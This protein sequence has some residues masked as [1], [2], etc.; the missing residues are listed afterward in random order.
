[1]RLIA[2]LLATAFALPANGEAQLLPF[3]AFAARD[4]RPGPGKSWRVDNERGAKLAADLTAAAK[5]T[6]V[7]I[8][9]DHNTL[10]VTRHGQRAP[11]AGW[12]QSA[13]WRD[14][15]GLFASVEWTDTAKGLIASGE[16]R[17]ISPVIAFD[18]ETG[19]VERVALAALVNHP[20]LQGMQAAVAALSTEFLSSLNPPSSEPPTMNELLL[21]LL[22][23]L[24]LKQDATQA[25]ALAALGALQ[26]P[27][28]STALA[29]ALG[30]AADADE[31]AQLAAL[32]AIKSPAGDDGATAALLAMQTQLAALQNKLVAGERE[33][34]V[35][36]ALSTG[37]LIPALVPWANTLSV[38]ALSAYIESAPVVAPAKGQSQG[39]AQHGA[40]PGDGVTLSPTQAMLASQLGIDPK[41]YAKQL[42][43][44]PV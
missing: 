9:Y 44:A 43:A 25:Q 38:E 36:A 6:P 16:Y 30:V 32:T 8:D 2:A 40:K 26:K 5:A 28:L 42:A 11:A 27:K 41:E 21:A 22:N 4:G 37:R 20:A 31:A 17:Y 29:T 23:A 19:A 12:I 7:V 13:E 35:Q 1:M 14:G 24:G 33:G 39:D 3:G 15:V 10:F 34:I 18:E